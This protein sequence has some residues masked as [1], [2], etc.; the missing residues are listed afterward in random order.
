MPVVVEEVII[1][2]VSKATPCTVNVAIIKKV[3]DL[4][5]QVMPSRGVGS[6]VIVTEDGYIVT[7]NHLVGETKEI[8]VTLTDGRRFDAHLVGTA[9]VRDIAVI[10][11]EG[12]DLP[13]AEC[14]DS[15]KLR[16][17]QLAIAIGNPLGIKGAP[18]VTAG[19]VS[20]VD[21]AI[22]SPHVLLEALIQTDAAINPG[23]S[24]GALV[25]SQGRVIGINTAVIP[26]AQGVGFAIPINTARLFAE[27]IMREGT[28]TAPWLGV[29][30]IALDLQSARAYNVAA[31]QGLLVMQ[32]VPGSPAHFAR[33]R[34]GDVVQALDSAQIKKLKDIQTSVLQKNVGDR[35][36]LHVLR[37]GRSRVIDVTLKA[38]EWGRPGLR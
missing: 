34:P 37:G 13:S 21:R 27:R 10:K 1:A 20:A 28:I 11:V 30:G 23:N 6:G 12:R 15:D 31:D 9:A 2:A 22:V 17:G 32:V 7:N 29:F 3:Q 8:R 14:G 25:D 36:A 26:Y 16:V 19:V 5:F 33:I 24:G 4:P 38:A 35:V 18:T